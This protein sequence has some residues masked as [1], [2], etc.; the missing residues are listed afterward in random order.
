MYEVF[1]VIMDQLE[2]YG[3]IK[4]LSLTSTYGCID[5]VI[6]GEKYSVT[7]MKEEKKDD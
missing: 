2:G 6:N 7:I 1:K 3:D 4:C 5:T